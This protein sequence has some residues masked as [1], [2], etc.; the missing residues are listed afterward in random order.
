MLRVPAGNFRY[1]YTGAN[2]LLETTGLCKL[3]DF[4]VSK[5]MDSTSASVRGT[6]FF[7]SP[8]MCR[9]EA[10]TPAR[11]QR[12]DVW[13]VGCTVCQ[14]LTGKP[15]F[16]NRLKS[17]EA[18]MWNIGKLK[19][20]HTVPVNLP[21]NIEDGLR[22]FIRYILNPD[23]EERPSAAECLQH[24]FLRRFVN[25]AGASSSEL[26]SGLRIRAERSAS[27]EEHDRAKSADNP[28]LGAVDGAMPARADAA[29][30]RSINPSAHGA[31]G[32]LGAAG[33]NDALPVLQEEPTTPASSASGNGD[34]R[35]TF[36][37]G[38]RTVS[39]IGPHT[40][41]EAVV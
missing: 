8:E 30:I 13:S 27:Q 7:M 3:T 34:D 1:P 37:G 14:M 31:G 41:L 17:N 19:K 4:G 38:A 24:P 33:D 26:L 6:A 23:A 35:E 18:F 36:P 40:N 16:Q 21:E 11:Q 5:Y 12:S 39:V 28:D 22:D 2:V 32:G 9:G 10:G 25:T 15:P 29:S 20:G